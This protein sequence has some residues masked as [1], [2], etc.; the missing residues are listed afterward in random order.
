VFKGEKVVLRA[1]E[2]SDLPKLLA[3]NNDV[4]VELA[5]GGDPPMPQSMARLEADFEERSRHGGRDGSSF[6]IE[7]DGKLIGQCGLRKES[8]VDDT[9]QTY[10]L[11]IA[12]GDKAY[13]G[14]GYGRD[15]VR[16]LLVHAFRHRNAHKVWLNVNA[17]NERAIRSYFACGFVEEGRLRRH[18][19]GDG[20]Y[21]DLVYMGILRGEWEKR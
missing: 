21:I 2:K 3:F 20:R 16:L 18:V 14:K 19:W 15:A 8:L 10:E 11:G 6:A 9:A 1:L 5:G 4:E 17:T 13:W 7:A 12:I